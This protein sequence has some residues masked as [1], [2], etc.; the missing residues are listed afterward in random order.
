MAQQ[1]GARTAHAGTTDVATTGRTPAQWYCLLA[2][3]ALLLAGVLGFVADAS[4]DT[5][6]EGSLFLGLEVNGWHNLVH[7]ASG[8]VLLAAAWKA[9]PARTIA[10]LFGLTYG[11]VAVIGLIDGDSVF[12]LLPVNAGVHVVHVALSAVGILAALASPR[13]EPLRAT[14][15]AAT[16]RGDGL[17]ATDGDRDE[18]F[19]RDDV[20]TLTGRPRDDRTTRTS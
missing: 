14:T 7:L 19:G 16:A 1:T 17:P 8:A 15:G 5:T 12:G 3:G 18:R 6:G 4:F 13:G 20:D 11:A 2:G 9:T 10:L